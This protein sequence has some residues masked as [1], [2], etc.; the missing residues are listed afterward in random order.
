MGEGQRLV[1]ARIDD[2]RS[3]CVFEDFKGPLT[4]E[5]AVIEATRCLYCNDAPCVTACPTS[6]EIPEF[7]RKI[8]TGN[9]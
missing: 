3:E 6:I 9:V 4:P 5:Q 1:M 2:T 7:I 8:S